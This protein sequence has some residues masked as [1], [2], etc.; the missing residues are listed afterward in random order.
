MVSIDEA[1]LDN[2]V[3]TSLSGPHAGIA[4]TRGRAL[5]YSADMAPFL[6]LPSDPADRDW[7]DAIDLLAPAT[8]VATLRIPARVPESWSVINTFEVVQMIGEDVIGV[9]DPEAVRLGPADVSEMAELVRETNPG[10][11]LSRTVE[12]G[13]YYGIRRDGQLVAMAG[14]R[15]HIEG[16]TEISAVCTAPPHRG[17]GIASR[18]VR[19]VVTGIERRSERAFLHTGTTNT[20]AINLYGALGFRV[21]RR[22]TITVISAPHASGTQSQVDGRP[23]RD[24]TLEREP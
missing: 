16:W 22:L 20:T 9:E 3:Y 15:L 11:F 17:Q 18:L 7:R 13:G 12:L 14:E 4:Q 5:R 1:L 23:R 24:R 19:A 2:P 21:R 10:P 8:A 6:A